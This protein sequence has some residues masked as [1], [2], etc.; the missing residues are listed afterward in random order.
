MGLRSVSAA[1]CRFCCKSLKA[2][3]DKFPAKRRNKPG[4]LIDV[5]SGSLPKAPVSLSLGDEI[6]HMFTRKPRLQLEKLAIN[7]AKRLLQQ[8]L[9]QAYSCTA[10]NYEHLCS[11]LRSP[12]LVAARP[13]LYPE[14]KGGQL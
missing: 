11:M 2:P 10:A 14:F 8:N 4:S 7:G 9:P 6:P 1:M 5:A 12:M 13:V 3:G